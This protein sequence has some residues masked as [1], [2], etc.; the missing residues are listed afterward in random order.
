MNR[1]QNGESSTQMTPDDRSSLTGCIG[2]VV[3]AQVACVLKL[4]ARDYMAIRDD[5][6]RFAR[7]GA[8]APTC[9]LAFHAHG[10]R[11]QLDGTQLSQYYQVASVV[12]CQA[13]RRRAE[14]GGASSLWL[15]T[16]ESVPECWN[17]NKFVS[18]FNLKPVFSSC[19]APSQHFSEKRYSV[20]NHLQRHSDAMSG[21]SPDPEQRRCLFAPSGDGTADFGDRYDPVTGA[22]ASS[23][24]VATVRVGIVNPVQNLPHT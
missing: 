7:T 11:V 20:H 8:P 9:L 18:V 22:Q 6:M 14:R 1:W 16:R 24:Q 23:V 10:T 17:R 13:S 15:F 12:P 19:E 2:V 3:S 21:K 4:P 5:V